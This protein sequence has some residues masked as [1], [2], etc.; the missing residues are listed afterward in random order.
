ME[1]AVTIVYSKLDEGSN[2]GFKKSQEWKK[3][4]YGACSPLP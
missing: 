3:T 4:Y 1:T 2:E